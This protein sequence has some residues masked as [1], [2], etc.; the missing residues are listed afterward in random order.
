[1]ASVCAPALW[2][3]E[4][5]YA[6]AYGQLET[7]RD[8]GLLAQLPLFLH[9]LGSSMVWR[10]NFAAAGSLVAEADAVAEATGTRFVRSAAVF[11]AG[12]RGNEADATA[13]IEVE[14]RNASSAGGDGAI[15]WCQWVSGVLYNG[16]GRYEQALVEAQ[17]A[18]EMRPELGLC[19]WARVELIEAASR[20]GQA[21]LGVETLAR[22]AQAASIA[23]SDWGLG[24]YARSRALLSGDDDAESSYREAIERLRRTQLRPE[25]ARSHLVYGEWLRR[26]GRRVDARAQLRSAHDLFITIGME[27]FAE[28]TRRELLA[29]G[30]HVRRRIVE[31]RDDLTAQERQIALLARD[32]MSNIEIG[33]RLFLSQHTVA[34]H[35]RKVFSKLGISSRRDLAA[36]L[37]ESES[38]LVPA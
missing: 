10:G 15:R 18:S 16:L 14:V 34:Y 2:D 26:E 21:R 36:A 29:T 33:T 31:T 1:L 22:L 9:R 25:L 32:G 12:L 6:V 30:D 7:V 28:R 5:S 23:D 27:A 38:G 4:D 19:A 20:T 35:L 13:L 37:P 11:L 8:A 3:E 17:R 24:V